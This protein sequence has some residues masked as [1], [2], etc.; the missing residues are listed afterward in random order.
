[1]EHYIH[2]YIHQIV[3]IH[4]CIHAHMHTYIYTYSHAYIHTLDLAL[5]WKAT[6]PLHVH[7]HYRIA[8]VCKVLKKMKLLQKH[9]RIWWPGSTRT[10]GRCSVFFE[11]RASTI[12]ILWNS[13]KAIFRFF[14]DIMSQH[15]LFFAKVLRCDFAFRSSVCRGSPRLPRRDRVLLESLQW[16]I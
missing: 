6:G 11:T 13:A 9:F 2:A 8:K 16:S 7:C 5:E 15:F 4:A 12:R 10:R 3:Y 14:S 1:M